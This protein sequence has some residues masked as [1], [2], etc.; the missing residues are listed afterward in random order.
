MNTELIRV[1]VNETTL[2]NNFYT[3]TELKSKL[4][5]SIREIERKIDSNTN[6][7]DDNFRWLVENYH[8]LLKIGK[9]LVFREIKIRIELL[10]FLRKVILL[11]GFFGEKED[12]FS[13]FDEFTRKYS[14]DEKE[15]NSIGSALILSV[16]LELERCVEIDAEKIPQLIQCIHNFSG[17]DFFKLSIQFSPLEKILRLDPAGVYPK[18][19]KSTKA[20]YRSRIEKIARKD[21]MSVEKV[22]EEMLKSAVADDKHIGFYLNKNHVQPPY[23]SLIIIFSCL[24]CFGLSLFVQNAFLGFLAFP[25]MYFISKSFVDHVYSATKNFEILPAMKCETVEDREK[26]VVAITTLLTNE[27]DLFESV[28]KLEKYCLNNKSENDRLYFGLICDLP[29]SKSKNHKNDENIIQLLKQEIDRLN[30]KN[31]CYFAVIRE[32]VYH[33]SENSYVGWERKRGAIEQF[34]E[35]LKFGSEIKNITFFGN[36][37]VVG[38]KYLIT[39]DSDTELGIGQAKRL[40]GK[41][42]H[43]L[44]QPRITKLA[45]GRKYVT[46]GHGLIQPRI[47][48]SLLTPITTPYAKIFSNGSGELPYSGAAFDSMQTLFEEGNFCGKGI[49]DLEAYRSVVSNT[50]PEQRILSHDMIEGALLRSAIACDEYFMDSDPQTAISSDKRIHRWI[51]GDVQN[52][53]FYSIIPGLRCCFAAENILRYFLPLAELALLVFS[54]FVSKDCAAICALTVV[55]FEFYPLVFDA[56]KFLV[57]RNFQLFGRRFRTKIRNHLLNTLYQRLLSFAGIAHKAYHY[58]DAMLRGFYRAF[59]SKRKTL[60]WQTY[61]PFS[62]Q[63]KDQMLFYL[64]SVLISAFILMFSR[65][66]ILFFVSLSFLFYPII[67]LAISEKYVET[68]LIDEKKR[69]KLKEFAILEFR[70]FQNMVN[71]KSS[72][73]PPDNIQFEPVEKIANRTSPTNIGLYL[74]SLV[75]AVDLG[76]ISSAECTNLIGKAFDSIENMEHYEG[77][78]YNWYDLNTLNVIGDRFVSTVD[79]GNYIASL[80]VVANALA[81]WSHENSDSKKLLTRVESEIEN[82]N[83]KCLFDWSENL[84]YVG[85]FTNDKKVRGSHYDLY[86][87]EARITSFLAISLGQ[88]PPSHWHSTKR[89]VL[90]LAGRVGIGSW[91]GTCFE[92]FMPTLFLPIIENSLEDESLDFA[93]HCQKKYA[94]HREFGSIYGI[95]ESGY[96]LTDDNENLQYMAFGVPYLSIVERKYD[97][98][99]ISPYSTFLMLS[100]GGVHSFKNLDLLKKIG[101]LGPMGYFEAV[102]FSSGRTM[103]F[104]VV[105]SYMAHHKGM[106]FL[107]IANALCDQKNVQRFMSRMG[108]NEKTELLAERFPIEGKV[109]QRKHFNREN[110]SKEVKTKRENLSLKLKAENGKLMTDG[111]TAFVAYDDGKNRLLYRSKDVFDHEKGGLTCTFFESGEEL[112]IENIE[113]SKIRF[114][115][116]CFEKILIKNKS[117][118]AVRYAP[119]YGKNAFFMRMEVNGVSENCRVEVDF[120]FLY[121]ALEVY[122]AH[123]AFH[124]LSLEGC[125]GENKLILRRRGTE[126]HD[127]V[128][129][130]SSKPFKTKFSH[131][132]ESESFD[133]RMLYDSDVKII[134]DLESAE[135]LVIPLVFSFDND[136]SLLSE[137]IFDGSYQFSKNMREISLHKLSRFHET[138]HLDRYS[139]NCL[140][141]ML[142]LLNATENFYQTDFDSSQKNQLWKYG[143]SGDR[144]IISL[145]LESSDKTAL[146]CLKSYISAFKALVLS[147]IN[148]FDFVILHEKSCGY[149]DHKREALSNIVS[150]LQCEFLIGKHPGIH[151]VVCEE[152]DLKFWKSV[153]A[154]LVYRG[155]VVGM[156]EIKEKQMRIFK[157]SSNLSSDAD[158]VGKFQNNGFVISKEKFN[159]NVP[160]S[161]V[162]S[163]PNIGFVC[164]QNSLGF[165][166]FRNSGLN[167]ISRWDNLPSGDDGEKI[168]LSKDGIEYD[169]LQIA[170]NISYKSSMA[171]Y[172]GEIFGEQYS[173]FATLIK[174]FSAKSIVVILS[175][176]LKDSKLIFSFVPSL[177]QFANKNVFVDLKDDVFRISPAIYDDYFGKSFFSSLDKKASCFKSQNRLCFAVNSGE[178]NFFFLG[179]YT[180]ETHLE[181][182]RGGLK[183]RAKEMILSNIKKS[184]N[185]VQKMN[186]QEFWLQYQVLHSRFYGRTG[187]Y[188]SSGAYGFRDQ[189]QD[190]LS[191]IKNDPQRTRVHL[192]RCASHQFE[193]GDV[194]HWWHTI[195]NEEKWDPGVRTRCSDDYLWLIYGVT[196]YMDQTGDDS[197]LNV[198]IPFLIGEELNECEKEKYIST[199]RGKSESMLVHLEKAAKLFLSKGLGENNLPDIGIGD[200]NDGMNSVEGDSVWLAFFSAICLNRVKKHLSMQTQAEIECVLGK[201]KSGLEKSFNGSWFVRAHRRNGQVLGNDRLLQSECSIDLITQA[202]AAFYNLEFRETKHKLDNEMVLSSLNAA[203][204]ILVD[205]KH[206]IIKL[207]DKPFV[208]TE[209]SPGYIQRYCAGVRENGGQYTHAAVWFA[210]AMLDFGKELK[211]DQLI[212]KAR[213]LTEI[214]DPTINVKRELF[215]RYQ[216]EPYVLC[217]DIYAAKGFRGHGGWSWYTGAA[218][219][220]LQL[221]EKWKEIEKDSRE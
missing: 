191:F 23:F 209:P 86:M 21:K 81:E 5:K 118:F 7:N 172:E 106:S 61:T 96:L 112:T 90:S 176:Q 216:R 160:F 28:K 174:E 148:L 49:I 78:L 126:K 199:C 197:I 133:W 168:F 190:C 125:A 123:S 109:Y 66:S 113:R 70:F 33:E 170:R 173:V 144:K 114:D 80:V 164:N 115:G 46:S 31:D 132:K 147:G 166:W 145:F 26:T 50:L 158:E 36:R 13:V 119:I 56:V 167:R 184:V 183:E 32:R 10:N 64:P 92:Y 196:V 198:E 12:I 212:K 161:H 136:S 51:R 149:F 55:I 181:F 9:N 98:K 130:Y 74:A 52:I 8:F 88:I 91:S 137:E 11:E 85:I 187:L 71:E 117:S 134:F 44:N 155:N 122:R 146:K 1:L 153:S 128:L 107:S 140:N 40:I 142:L 99:V 24:F 207:F 185:R 206:R 25:L 43:P 129:I 211:D 27:A 68:D 110:T 54:N 202:F 77:H 2:S 175:N 19:T 163:A 72:F 120:H 53:P 203:F 97:S 143:I 104:G 180:N 42:I 213:T 192:I 139:L 89:P 29:Q 169:L 100:K 108:F 60:E 95:S 67:M 218:S 188:Q 121:Q 87:S 82:A 194:L 219:W 14:I 217:G 39:L 204:E 34:A 83:F 152:M 214:L 210:M 18:M 105:R 15:L 45:N 159:P 165:T 84:F 101:C 17:I 127:V 79:S 220:Y 171:I 177:G 41:M 38:S 30:E 48:P 62:G 16:F 195:R 59:I 102:E 111:K 4:K 156:D 215:E 35:F 69:R 138:C 76:I 221:L 37:N 57:A 58:S 189:L 131:F 141:E 154:R 186:L 178:E 3:K 182:I 179:G 103:D 93:Y 20:L 157:S 162:V 193:E 94:A 205:S 208:N 135:S 150:Q 63:N 6:S 73:L 124:N 22:A 200:W 151:F 65:V 116:I 201:L 75:S 47:A